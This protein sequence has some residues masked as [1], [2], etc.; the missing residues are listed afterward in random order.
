LPEK[1]RSN[2]RHQLAFEAYAA[3]G[4]KRS[5]KAVAGQFGVALSTVKGWAKT[6]QWNQRLAEREAREARLL[7]DRSLQEGITETERNLKIVRMTLVKLAKDIHEGRVKGVISDVDRLVRLE[8]HLTGGADALCRDPRH[9]AWDAQHAELEKMGFDELQEEMF[10]IAVDTCARYPAHRSRMAE[11][12][13]QM[14]GRPPIVGGQERPG[15]DERA[16]HEALRSCLP[17]TA[18]PG[19]DLGGEGTEKYTS[20]TGPPKTP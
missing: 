1:P 16:E 9:A 13:K 14:E 10:Q 3:M 12:L 20:R 19:T 8:E 18:E 2:N 11:A 5:Y 6:G 15:Y 4:A 7:A 17:G